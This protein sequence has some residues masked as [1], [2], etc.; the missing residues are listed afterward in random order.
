[1]FNR[2]L[3]SLPYSVQP[4]HKHIKWLQ[5]DHYLE[6]KLTARMILLISYHCPAWLIKRQK[7]AVTMIMLLNVLP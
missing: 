5:P 6:H 7:L 4:D 1:M 2:I 3:N